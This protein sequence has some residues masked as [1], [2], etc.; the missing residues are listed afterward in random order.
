MEY[1]KRFYPE[2]RYGGFTDIDSSIAFYL[3][4]NAHIST[5]AVLLDYGCGRGHYSDD[6]IHLRRDLQVF[7]NKCKRVIGLDVDRAAS[8]NPFLDEFHLI[9]P[10][11]NW[12]VQDE[13]VDIVVCDWVLE[14]LTKPELF[15]K[16]CARVLK[17]GGYL[18]LRTSNLFHYRTILAILIPKRYHEKIVRAAQRGTHRT[19]SDLF[20]TVYRCNTRS[21]ILRQLQQHGFTNNVVYG[22]QAEPAYLS[23]SAFTYSLGKL[24]QQIAPKM[25]A[26]AIFAF[27]T[28]G[29]P[30][31][32]AHV[33]NI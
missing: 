17:P 22:Y 3:R 21:K 14:H 33:E 12:P 23:F 29:T 24:Y 4:V 1:K 8:K 26:V 32:S 6:P 15:F 13:T 28:K 27:A 16:E 9:E 11:N 19:D 20:P 2:S 31:K 18:F 30:S 10:A 7:K 25:F 5:G